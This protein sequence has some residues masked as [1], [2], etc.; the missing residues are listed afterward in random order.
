MAETRP[1]T[2]LTPTQWDDKFF[3][4]Y[5]QENRFAAYMGETPN[6]IIQIR[7]ELIDKPGQTIRVPF[8]GQLTGD[9]IVG[10][11]VLEGQ[12]EEIGTYFDDVTVNP[13]AKAVQVTK[14]ANQLSAIQLREAGREVLKDWSER[15]LRDQVISSFGAVGANGDVPYATSTATER[16]AWNVLNQDRILYG[17]ATANYNAVHAT[18][19][20]NV[21]TVND[22]L[23]RQNL[24]IMK[25][26]A[27]TGNPKIAPI[28]M[29][30]G[31]KRFYV[32]FAHPLAFRDLFRDLEQANR[33]VTL[34]DKNVIL[35]KGGDLNYEGVIVHEVD[36][37]PI[38]QGVGT[39]GANVTPVYLCGQQALGYG[40]AKRFQTKDKEFDY[41]RR[42]GIAMEAWYGIKKMVRRSSD[43]VNSLLVGKQVGVVTGFFAAAAD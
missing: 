15:D 40:L 37:L 1:T 31:G 12:E 7:E 9:T 38:L 28:R 17:N 22:R 3:S 36:D 33:D 25:R 24:S 29:E 41:E 21:D 13:R 42:N 32:A 18:A 5:F 34:E 23:T 35:F 19:L 26:M 14:W 27:T 30:K 16:N 39:S 8:V 11:G 10:D 4:E 6:S 2:E 20:A 43:P